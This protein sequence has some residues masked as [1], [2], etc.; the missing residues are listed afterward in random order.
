MSEVNNP[1]SPYYDPSL[2]FDAQLDLSERAYS[3]FGDSL[4]DRRQQEQD[5][6]AWAVLTPLLEFARGE[7]DA[8]DL[9]RAYRQYWAADHQHFDRAS[10]ASI[11]RDMLAAEVMPRKQKIK[12]FDSDGVAREVEEPMNCTYQTAALTM[13]RDPESVPSE[14]P[15]AI[16]QAWDFDQHS[17][18]FYPVV[19]LVLLPERISRWW[20]IAGTLEVD[21]DGQPVP[22]E[23]DRQVTA[24]AH[25]FT[26]TELIFRNEQTR[27]SGSRIQTVPAHH[28]PSIFPTSNGAPQYHGIVRRFGSQSEGC[29]WFD[30]VTAARNYL[31]RPRTSAVVPEVADDAP[32]TVEEVTRR[33]IGSR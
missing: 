11:G 22:V 20:P 8:P 33:P 26:P 14:V 23:A 31:G 25:M 30:R 7:S 2:E 9:G 21:D 1:S 28:I 5:A 18:T 12:V 6:D 32:L 4:A 29:D 16:Y 3:G 13:G 19:S 10:V 24:Y 17:P 27:R 15:N